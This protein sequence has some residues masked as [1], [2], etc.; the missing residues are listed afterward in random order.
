MQRRTHFGGLRSA[1]K[2]ASHTRTGSAMLKAGSG[3]SLA[4]HE[5]QNV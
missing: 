5:L 4:E 3:A 1:S 2:H